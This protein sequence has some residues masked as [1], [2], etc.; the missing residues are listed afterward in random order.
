M[1]DPPAIDAELK[2]FLRGWLTSYEQLHALLLLRQRSGE[3]LSQ[4]SSDTAD[5]R[6]SSP[7]PTVSST[8]EFCPT[9]V[10][11]SLTAGRVVH[12]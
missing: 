3:S 10:E 1:D 6:Q 11:W 12:K 8:A 9:R 7:T 2:S 4:R 5:H